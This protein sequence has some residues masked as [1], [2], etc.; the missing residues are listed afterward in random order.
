MADST[1]EYKYTLE[2]STSYI[3]RD[4]VDNKVWYLDISSK[5]QIECDN[6]DITCIGNRFFSSISG[7]DK[8]EKL[9]WKFEDSTETY[10]VVIMHGGLYCKD[11]PQANFVSIASKF[12]SYIVGGNVRGYQADGAYILL[13]FNTTTGEL[14]HVKYIAP[15]DNTSAQIGNGSPMIEGIFL[16]S[17]AHVMIGQ[18]KKKLVHMSVG[19]LKTDIVD[20]SSPSS[21]CGYEETGIYEQTDH[22]TYTGE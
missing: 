5:V 12:S 10:D 4:W 20:E 15:Y 1:I 3:N 7:S 16:H 22:Y 11:I 17:S 14:E 8:N 2:D 21:G 6:T 18:D 13:Y 9:L 19:G